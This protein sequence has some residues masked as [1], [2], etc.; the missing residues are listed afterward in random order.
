VE[1]PRGTGTRSN[2]YVTAAILVLSLRPVNIGP[3][4]ISMLSAF[5][6]TAPGLTPEGLDAHG[7]GL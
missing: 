1:D 5:S 7:Q 6:S 2:R 4:V 3:E